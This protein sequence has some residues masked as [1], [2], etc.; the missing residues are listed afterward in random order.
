M[1]L[2]GK[3]R[4]DFYELLDKHKGDVMDAQ[5][6]SMMRDLQKERLSMEKAFAHQKSQMG[7]T[8]HCPVQI[9]SDN[10]LYHCKNLHFR[11]KKS[12]PYQ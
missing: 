7:K 12:A 8:S 10:K 4:D 5:K 2:K 11:Q 6:E 3:L 1:A 9:V